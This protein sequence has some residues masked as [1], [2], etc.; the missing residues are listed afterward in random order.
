MKAKYK[1]I[2]LLSLT[3]LLPGCGGWVWLDGSTVDSGS[4]SAARKQCRIEERME[5]L[6]KAEDARDEQLSQ[7][8]TDAAEREAR[9]NFKRIQ[10]LHDAEIRSC[11]R[12][13]GLK[14][15]Q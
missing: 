6:E 1:L 8:K 13:L 2:P 3:L 10:R 11:M 5:N 4:L 9:E 15:S 14:P 7:A 12:K